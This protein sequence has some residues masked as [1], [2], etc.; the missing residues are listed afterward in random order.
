MN[1]A[2][3]KLQNGE[4]PEKVIEETY[5]AIAETFDGIMKKE[6]NL[7]AALSN[8]KSLKKRI[9]MINDEQAKSELLATIEILTS[10]LMAIATSLL[11]SDEISE[12]LSKII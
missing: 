9:S 8:I 7:I 5:R 2:N 4:N 3:E 11:S 10:T 6:D 1:K 12:I